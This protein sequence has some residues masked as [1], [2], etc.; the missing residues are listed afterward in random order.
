MSFESACAQCTHKTMGTVVQKNCAK[1][2]GKCKAGASSTL[3]GKSDDSC[4]LLIEN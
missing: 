2:C 3:D 4:V 1:T